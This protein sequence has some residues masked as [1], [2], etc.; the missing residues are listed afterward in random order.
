MEVILAT[1][2]GQSID[3]I[4]GEADTLTQ[5]AASLFEYSRGRGNRVETTILN[6]KKTILKS[7]INNDIFFP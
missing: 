4:N 5:A 3:V 7:N 1:G 2:F 6:S